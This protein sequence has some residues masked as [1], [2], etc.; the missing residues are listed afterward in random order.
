MSQNTVLCVTLNKTVLLFQEKEITVHKKNKKKGD[1]PIEKMHEE[2]FTYGK[3]NHAFSLFE[4]SDPNGTLKNR[5]NQNGGLNFRNNV[6]NNKRR[7]KW[8]LTKLLHVLTTPGEKTGNEPVNKFKGH[9]IDRLSR[10][11]FPSSYVLFIVVYLVY[12]LNQV[13]KV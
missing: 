12:Y 11:I 4:I 3:E 7:N 5:A 2:T 10:I 8:V 13:K 9:P 6:H 1:P